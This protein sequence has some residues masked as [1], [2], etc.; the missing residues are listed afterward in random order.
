MY[1][2]CSIVVRAN[3]VLSFSKINRVMECL[4]NNL[5]LHNNYIV[6]ALNNLKTTNTINS[7]NKFHLCEFGS[8]T[9][10]SFFLY[11]KI[12]LN[13]T[14]HSVKHIIFK[15]NHSGIYSHVHFIHSIY[16][17]GIEG[18]TTQQKACYTPK[19]INNLLVILCFIGVQWTGW[20]AF[21][22]VHD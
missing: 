9:R 22:F 3:G 17:I 13:D 6:Y 15:N 11:Y 5:N 21:V 4:F 16:I 7:D 8:L 20:I 18:W 1:V 10:K 19:L 2:L 14:I 12:Q